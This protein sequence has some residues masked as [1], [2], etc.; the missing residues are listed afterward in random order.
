MPKKTRRVNGHS[1]VAR[2]RARVL[3]QAQAKGFI[4]ND[5]AKR[6]GNWDQAWYHLSK[7]AKAGLLKHVGFNRW[8]V[9]RRGERVQ[10]SA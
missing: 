10:L 8:V 5:Q 1:A 4:T 9:T 2:A 3:K 6:T 7:L